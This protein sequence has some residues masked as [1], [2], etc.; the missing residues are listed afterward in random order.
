MKILCI[1]ATASFLDFA[2][3]CEAMGHEVRVFMGPCKDGSRYPVGDGLLTKVPEWQGSMRWADLIITSDNVKYLKEMESYRRAGYPIF[4]PNMEVTDWEL[5]R[6]T[7]QDIFEDHGIKCLPSTI[8]K[9]YDEAIEFLNK[10]PEGRYVS[11][12]TGDADKALSYVSKSSQDMMFMLNHWKRKQI[13][14][15]PFLFQEFRPGI[16]MAVG[17]WVGR[18]GF[19][20]HFLENFEFKKLM[21][22]EVGVNTGEMG[23]A[24]KYVTA[25][26]S[27]L[28]RTVL[29]PLEAALIRSGYTGYI[30]VAVIIDKKGNPW[31]LEFTS[32]PGW[33][34]FQI[35]QALHPDPCQWMLD[36][37]NGKDTFKPFDD[38]AI[39]VVVT[40]PDFPYSHMTRKEVTGFPVWGITTK[41]RFNVHP[42]EMMLGEAPV[43]E[44]GKIKTKQMMVTAGDYVLVVTGTEPTI[45]EAKD[46]AY[47]VLRQ[48][49]IPNSPIYRTDIGCRLEKQ[50]PELQSLGYATSWEW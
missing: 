41:N 34:L 27:L 33:P 48:L 32:R 44:N 21:N 6:G 15:V 23:T 16:E 43:L 42:C 45:S 10:N 11:K 22:D 24:M 39:G 25:E 31:P 47:D 2:M 12:P 1:D 13:S 36:A 50:I 46:S 26:E 29:L 30:D 4:G 7:G 19:L 35:Q 28:A 14:K 8:F 3:R 17:G 38:I 5:E 18:D 9:T 20:S 49:E 40:M 37:L